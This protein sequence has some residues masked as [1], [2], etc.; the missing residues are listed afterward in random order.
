MEND[1]CIHDL[2]F[3]TRAFLMH[4]LKDTNLDTKR[5]LD[6]EIGANGTLQILVP[7]LSD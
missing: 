4:E 5:L 2:R 3:T 1:S 7:K 6:H